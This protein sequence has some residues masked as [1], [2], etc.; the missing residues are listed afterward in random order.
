MDSERFF[1]LNSMSLL[2]GHCFL[3]LEKGQTFTSLSFFF[4]TAKK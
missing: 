2:S 4:M 3:F 1:F